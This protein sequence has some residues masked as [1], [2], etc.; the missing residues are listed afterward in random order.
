MNRVNLWRW[1][2]YIFLKGQLYL[3]Y[4]VSHASLLFLQK[5]HRVFFSFL[6]FLELY[7]LPCLDLKEDFFSAVPWFDLHILHQVDWKHSLY[8]NDGHSHSAASHYL[9]KFHYEFMS[10]A[11][12]SPPCSFEIR[13]GE[14]GVDAT[15]KPPPRLLISISSTII[16][17]IQNKNDQSTTVQSKKTWG[18]FSHRLLY[19]WNLGSLPLAITLQSCFILCMSW[20][21]LDYYV[22]PKTWWQLEAKTLF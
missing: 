18:Q 12:S 15:V 21:V 4:N 7:R 6:F 9:G 3:L 8:I 16:L 5:L 1:S 22:K 11:F 13:C 10:S 20:S 14:R 2:L 19:N 17:T